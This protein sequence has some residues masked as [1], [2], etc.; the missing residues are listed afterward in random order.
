LDDALL[1]REGIELVHQAFGMDPA[2]AVVADIELA[3]V[4][5]DNHGVGQKAVGLDGVRPVYD[6]K[7]A[8]ERRIG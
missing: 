3:G 5:A 8:R 4:V 7:E 1:V 6:V 2:Q